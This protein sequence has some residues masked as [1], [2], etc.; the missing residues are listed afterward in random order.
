[1]FLCPYCRINMYIYRL[2]VHVSQMVSSFRRCYST[3]LQHGQFKTSVVQPGSVLQFQHSNVPRKHIDVNPYRCPVPAYT[4]SNSVS[5]CKMYLA[6]FIR[7]LKTNSHHN[8][9]NDNSAVKYNKAKF[10]MLLY[11]PL[12]Q[13]LRL[14]Y[15][16]D[17]NDPCRAMTTRVLLG[18]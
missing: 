12:R 2:L 8:T 14:F 3:V 6:P 13:T 17:G 4:V 7:A 5:L 11:Q 18:I 16:L 15:A 1:M 10:Q 9:L